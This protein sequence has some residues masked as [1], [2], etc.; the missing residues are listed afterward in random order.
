MTKSIIACYMALN[1]FFLV[2]RGKRIELGEYDWILHVLSVGTPSAL[3]IVFLALS[4][5]GPSGAWCFVDARDQARADAVNYALY[6][7]VIVCFI[8]ICLSYVAVW[9]RIS[10]SAKALKSS[11]ARNS[12]T[13]RSAKT[14]MLFTLAYFGEWITYLLY[15]IWSIFSTPHVVSV[16][17]VVTLCNMGGV[18]YCMAYLVF[19]KRESKTDAQTIENASANIVHKS[20]STQE[21]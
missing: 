3:A 9:I 4:F 21:S 8:V 2:V 5:Y 12:R 6:A 11:T 14:M 15:A 13:N 18:Y 19:K 17:L 7:V 1:A 16:F 10:R 20:P